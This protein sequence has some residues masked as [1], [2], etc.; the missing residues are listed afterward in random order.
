LLV[1]DLEPLVVATPSSFAGELLA[2]VGAVNVAGETH[3]PFS[4]LSV[5]AAVA[6]VP[7]VIILAGVEPPAGRPA[8]RGLERARIVQ[9]RSTALIHP[10]PRLVEAI[11]DLE[12]AVRGRPQ[13]D[14]LPSSAQSSPS[15]AHPRPTSPDPSAPGARSPTTRPGAAP[16]SLGEAGR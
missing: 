1:F 9:L 16:P 11:D 13:P 2:D 4:R 7:E 15:A 5:E 8:I 6:A 3:R 12:A 14:P 10:G